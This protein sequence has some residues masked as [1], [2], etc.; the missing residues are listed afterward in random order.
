MMRHAVRLA[1]GFLLGFA[2]LPAMAGPRVV[3][4]SGALE[5]AEA[6]GVESF[7]GIPFAA[8]PVGALRWRAPQPALPWKGVRQATAFGAD[9][10]QWP[11]DYIPGPGYV[12]PT[13]EDC[14]T[15]NVWRPVAAKKLPVMVWI[16]G[17]AWSMGS[18]AWPAYRGANLAAQ[19]VVM[20]SLNYRIGRFGFFAHPALTAANPDGGML[21]NYGLM[22]Q[23]AALK[24]VKA[25]IAAFGG[26]PDQVTIF[27]ESAGGFSVNALIASPVARGLFA[28]AIS[29]S[30]GGQKDLG[31]RPDTMLADAEK[32]GLAWTQS[33]G[34]A[35][36]D[37]SAMRALPAAAVLGPQ[38]PRVGGGLI[39][40]GGII[41]QPVD[42]AFL[43]GDVAHVAY[44]V[45]ANS[46]EHSLLQWI[47]GGAEAVVKAMGVRATPLLALYD[48]KQGN[49]AEQMWGD[50]FMVAPSRFLARRMA[51]TGAPAWLYRYSYVPVVSRKTMTGATH[52]AEISLVLRNEIDAPYF[53]EGT[54]DVPMVDA[55][56]GYWLRF[57]KTGNPNG[58]GAPDWP[59]YSAGGDAL[60]EFTN[61]GP[62]AR[63]GLNKSRL[64]MIDAAYLERAGLTEPR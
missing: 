47:P 53:K 1:A 44:L 26:D 52:A 56:S 8:P 28:R 20:V 27:G 42:E 64:D 33:I 41:P 51:A 32:S 5:G 17:G 54:A 16:Y 2:A 23:V 60:M 31:P 55:I 59:A 9:C 15:L 19:G 39:V 61:D 48:P 6:K 25:N 4:H 62:I 49:P 29:Q 40:D 57:A 58:P 43:K 30:G 63:R 24:W 46:K 21:G 50:A 13:S 12:R 18:G 37:L 22:D 3:T 7:L 45:G 35:D 11:L 36:R 10:M 34:I 38:N 14:L